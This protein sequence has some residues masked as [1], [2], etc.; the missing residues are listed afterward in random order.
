MDKPL[1]SIRVYWT[2]RY[3]FALVAGLA[4]IS[5]LSFWWVRHESMDRRLETTRI[6]AQE[7]ADKIVQGSNGE[8]MDYQRQDLNALINKRKNMIEKSADMCVI[9]TDQQ[10]K[11][12]FSNPPMSEEQMQQRLVSPEASGSKKITSPI[13]QSGTEIGEV[14]LLLPT[15]SFR[16]ITD[17]TWLVAGAF[18]FLAA[19]GWITIHLLTRKLVKPIR[20]VAEAAREIRYGNYDVT[21][22][23][24]AKEQEIYE[25][26]TSFKEMSE[27][28]KTLEHSRSYMLAGLTHELK[29][30]VTSIKGLLHA[31][32]QGVVEKEEAGEFMDAALK[33]TN[34]LEHM[35]ADLLDYNAIAAGVIPLRPER[36]QA[37]PFFSELIYQWSLHQSCDMQ[38]PELTWDESLTDAVLWEDPLRIQQIM[39]NLLN[40][41]VEAKSDRAFQLSI[42]LNRIEESCL[43][44]LVSDNGKG[45]PESEQELIFERFYRGND[46]KERVRGLGLGLSFSRLL[47]VNMGGNLRLADSSSEGSTFELQVPFTT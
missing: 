28:L 44:V 12:V 2:R 32:Q 47:A 7:I 31:V 13:M 6:V 18:A 25:L 1:R 29:T 41:S 45:I 14:V 33:E 23:T 34:R 35:V 37:V 17:Q 5:L 39:T 24:E 36:I 30:P 46:K 42:H 26:K 22:D 11:P 8:E 21:L 20:D 15:K 19:L 3:F 27:R 16:I 4:I 9:I 10:G 40:N 38:A 43:S